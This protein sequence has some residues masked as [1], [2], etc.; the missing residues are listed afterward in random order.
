MRTE[1]K[2]ATIPKFTTVALILK[3]QSPGDPRSLISKIP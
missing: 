2:K 1:I 3:E